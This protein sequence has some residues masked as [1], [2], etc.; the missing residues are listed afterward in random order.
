MNALGLPLVGDQLYPDVLHGPDDEEDFSAPL[1]LLA[2]HIAFTDPITGTERG[3]ESAIR[4]D[5][6]ST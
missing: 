3:F 4:L 2:K 1:R 5:W 6:P